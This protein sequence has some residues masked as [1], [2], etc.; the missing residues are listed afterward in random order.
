MA[1]IKTRSIFA[2]FLRFFHIIAALGVLGLAFL[3][4]AD[5]IG[6]SVFGSPVQG[7]PELVKNLI[8]GILFMQ[9]PFAIYSGSM[10]RTT[11][12]SDL[13]PL[14]AGLVLKGILYLL[15]A[16]LFGCIAYASLDPLL[17]SWEILEYDGEGLVKIPVYPIRFIIFTMS[18]LSAITYLVLIKDSFA[19]LFNNNVAQTKLRSKLAPG[20]RPSVH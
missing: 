3:I 5:V 6:R 7:I 19:L 2:P 16:L 9:L 12:L 14:R 11:F 17:T 13:L 20:I 8:V 15:G 18:I 10:L 4:L 1:D